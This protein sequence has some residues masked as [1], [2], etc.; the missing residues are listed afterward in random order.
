MKQL[1]LATLL[2]FVACAAP[3]QMIYRC[4]D[5]YSQ[6]PCPGGRVLESSDPRTGAQRA[7]AKRAAAKERQLAA[8]L[9]RERV[10]REAAAAGTSASG[11]DTAPKVETAAS[12]PIKAK[13]KGRGKPKAKARTAQ[14]DSQDYVALAPRPRKPVN[15]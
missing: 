2:L 13:G 9:E 8:K 4:G 3:A 15:E 12:E 11:F 7:E 1:A 10:A 5:T 6:T 14:A